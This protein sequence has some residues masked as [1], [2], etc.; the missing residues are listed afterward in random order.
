MTSWFD[1]EWARNLWQI[2]TNPHNSITNSKIDQFLAIPGIGSLY[3]IGA[4]QIG[5]DN[6]RW[7]S[8]PGWVKAMT[9]KMYTGHWTLIW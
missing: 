3:G 8:V 5:Q 6:L 1:H 7:S 4:S 2:L 9:Y